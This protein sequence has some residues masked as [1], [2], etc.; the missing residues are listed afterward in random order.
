LVVRRRVDIGVGMP[1]AT[2]YQ[3]KAVVAVAV[4]AAFFE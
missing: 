3:A 1:S 2:Q 4:V